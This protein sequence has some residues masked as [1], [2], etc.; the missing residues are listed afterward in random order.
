[1]TVILLSNNFLHDICLID[2]LARAY[3]ADPYFADSEKTCRFNICCEVIVESRLHLWLTGKQNVPISA[4]TRGLILQAFHDNPMVGH[5]GVTKTLKAIK[6]RFYWLN[7]DRRCVTMNVTVPTVKCRL[8]IPKPAG[9][10]QPLDAPLYAWHAVTTDYLTGLPV[11]LKGNNAIDVFVEK[12]TK[13]MYAV[14]CNQKYNA[15]L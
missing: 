8:L 1:M 13:Y 10:L 3:A 7:A 9:L 11:T 15:V 2:N 14:P 12:L 6:S 4:D 5:R